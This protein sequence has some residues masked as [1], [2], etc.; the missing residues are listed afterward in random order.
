MKLDPIRHIKA[1]AATWRGRFILAFLVVQMVLPLA[2]YTIRRDPHD[3]RYAWRM[4]SPMRMT[5]CT[6]GASIDKQPVNLGA[7]F[8]EAWINIAERGR[9]VVAEAIAARL[10]EKN[11]GKPVEMTLDCKYVDGAVHHFGGH[12]MCSKPEL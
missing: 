9:F 3:E 6:L 7:Q 12:D 8:H 4:F 5:E 11:P 10:C 2:Y 1:L